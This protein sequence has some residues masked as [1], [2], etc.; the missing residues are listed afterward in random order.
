MIDDPFLAAAISEAEMSLAEGG[1]A[2]RGG[3]GAQRRIVDR[4]HN[5]R[6]Q[7]GSP[8]LHSEM[9]ALESAGRLS[10]KVYAES[11]I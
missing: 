4:G 11:V 9:D 7:R 1:D 6:V 5:R 2:D 8:T 3:L 10:A